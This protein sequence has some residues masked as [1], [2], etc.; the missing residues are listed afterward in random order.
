MTTLNTGM[1]QHGP[2]IG[3]DYSYTCPAIC[4]LTDTPQWFVNYKKE[5]K[6]YPALPNVTWHMSSATTDIMRYIE[7]SEWAAE[8]VSRF[9]PEC[10]VLEDYAFSANG[11]ITQLSENTG[12]L[13]VKLYE[14]FPY[15]N[16]RVLAPTTMKKFATGRGIA[17]K[18]DI[19]SAFVT[20]FPE[21]AVWAKL[22][23][24]K[25]SRIG[26][27]VGDIADSYFL[28]QYGDTHFRHTLPPIADA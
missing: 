11:R 2:V 26:S 19:W 6:P 25:A 3:I 9:H 24:P 23:H 10:V 12:A 28:A 22:C 20:K 21:A 17:T 7:L 5:G 4:V 27:P 13:K 14:M 18:D 15:L 1:S 16:M 8:I